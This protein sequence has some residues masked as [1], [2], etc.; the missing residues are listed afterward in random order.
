ML[1]RF[2]R[3]SRHA[4]LAWLIL[5]GPC[6]AAVGPAAA[7]CATPSASGLAR[8][9][10]Q[11]AM[12]HGR[13]VAY[14]PTQIRI[15]DGR[16]SRAD[17]A[18]IRAD[19]KVLR[20]HF[21]SLVTYGSAN[22]ADRVA[23]VAAELGFRVVVLGIW[24]IDDEAEIRLALDAAARQPALVVGLSL[25]NERVLAGE[26]DYARLAER[27]N[28]LRRRAPKLA[29]STTEPFHLFEQPG[30]APL[31]AA[32]DF[33]LV[34]AHPVFQTWFAQAGPA[35][36]AR[37]VV[38]VTQDVAARFCGPVLVKETGVPTAPETMGFTAARQ[39]AF[40]RVLREA[41]PATDRTAFAYFS[42]FDAAWRVADS[43]PTAGPQPQ[44]GSWGLFEEGRSPKPAALELPGL[45]R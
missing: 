2:L 25:G 17:D 15:I 16:A 6:F 39:A 31:L 44:E 18:G 43:H 29:L 4:A 24:G 5:A 38:N 41:F 9:R 21:D 42:A 45:S 7:V 40:F 13:F 33:L 8:Q 35:D 26:T 10:L 22:G 28:Q 30:A 36:W 27:L 32:A 20:E 3:T 19:L 1:T 12:A 34:N 11:D 23:D 37:F 14:Q